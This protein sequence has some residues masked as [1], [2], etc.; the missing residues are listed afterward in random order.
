[1]H[2]H[3]CAR[4]RG[5]CRRT[6]RRIHCQRVV[7]DIND[8]RA[9]AGGNDGQRRVRSGDCRHDHFVAGADAGGA[10]EQG[11]G[12]SARAR[13]D[14][15]TRAACGREL[16]LERLDFRAEDVPASRD[17]TCDR[18]PHGGG[19]LAEVKIEEGDRRG[20]GHDAG[21]AAA[22]GT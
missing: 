2:R 5:D 17:D 15:D 13:A 10:Q 16:G 22:A 8:H 3:E 18:L 4:A 1:M 21:A 7:V 20:L 11:D 12:V 6:R 9:G 19:V 14:G